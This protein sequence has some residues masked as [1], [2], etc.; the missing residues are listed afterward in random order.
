MTVYSAID[1]HSSNSMVVVLD[2][3]DRVL[4]QR[5]VANRLSDI[6]ALL[7]PYR[8]QLHA[9]AVESTYNWY[10]LVD[11]LIDAAYPVVL[12]NT[13]A[14]KTYEGLKYSND[15][16]D[17]RWLAH[18]MRLGLLPQGYIYPREQRAV[19]D[20]LRKRMQLVQCRTQQVL[21]VKNVLARNLGACPTAA[22][23][24]RMQESDIDAALLPA[25]RLAVASNVAVMHCLQEQIDRIE[26][27]ALSATLASAA[28][29]SYRALQSVD[30]IG[31]VL[32]LT[33]A[34]ETGE[35]TRFARVGQF[36][37]Y[38]RC[39]GSQHISNE[40]VK[41]R[42]N[43]KNGNPYLAWAFIEAANFAIRFNPA[44]KRYYERKAKRSAH[45][46]VA[47]KAV[48]HK[49]ARACYFVMRDG[50]AFDVQRAFGVST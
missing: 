40:K 11:G 30:G 10:W 41:G 18:L 19:R 44:I 9:V 15:Q 20:L 33:I 42:G 25:Q 26:E 16:H 49:L 45:R 50:A 8:T 34:L 7:T 48:A 31:K 46:L 38:C 5:R 39:V 23:V 1:L 4:V 14:V 37:S 2:E 29:K 43:T 22:S 47:L 17:A 35:I 27:R 24:K 13:A 28:G 12:V 3:K 32:G 21:A 6:V 36:A